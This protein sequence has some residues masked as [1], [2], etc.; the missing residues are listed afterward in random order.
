MLDSCASLNQWVMLGGD[1]Y[2][3]YQKSSQNGPNFL[4]VHWKL[5]EL[6][7]I[8]EFLQQYII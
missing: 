8:H 4:A 7:L 6:Y 2:L 3:G 1:R 5:S